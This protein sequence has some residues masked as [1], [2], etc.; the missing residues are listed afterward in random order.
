MDAVAA[1]WRAQNGVRHITPRGLPCPEGRW[2]GEHLKEMGRGRRVLEFGCG[3]GRLSGLFSPLLYL[4]VD[5]NERS[6]A[7]A[8]ARNP[9]H[10]FQLATDEPLPSADLILCHT[11]LLHISDEDLNDVIGRMNAPVVV[12]NEMLGRSWRHDGEPPVFNRELGEYVA[13][14]KA[15][16]Y[17]LTSISERT[18]EHY[19]A[20]MALME[21][22][23]NTTQET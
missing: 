4:G 13:A 12:V 11:V 18:Y 5:I 17:K 8:K 20:P 3:P 15:H 1:F 16:D 14:F 22:T 9:A 19:N 21:F 23:R 6:L 7:E 2:L 10:V